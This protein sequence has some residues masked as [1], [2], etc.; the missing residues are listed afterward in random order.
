MKRILAITFVLFGVF[1]AAASVARGRETTANLIVT[2]SSAKIS[3]TDVGGTRIT[4]VKSGRYVI[5]VR[6]RSTRENFHLITPDPLLRL[7]TGL[8]YVGTVKWR[9]TLARGVYRFVSDG[10][11]SLRGSFKVV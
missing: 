5:V 3:L 8:G 4:S 6:D 9:I 11:H 2:V 1:A 10:R 7:R